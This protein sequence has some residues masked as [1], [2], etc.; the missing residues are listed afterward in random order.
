MQNVKQLNITQSKYF[1]L[2]RV[3]MVINSTN[4]NFLDIEVETFNMTEDKYEYLYNLD[5]YAKAFKDYDDDEQ[6]RW[7]EVQPS[8]LQGYGR[9]IHYE[10]LGFDETTGEPNPK[11]FTKNR[12][13]SITEGYFVKGKLHGYG[14]IMEKDK[15][16][17][18]F[19]KEGKM[20]GKCII[21]NF[22]PDSIPV[23]GIW[24]NNELIYEDQNITDFTS[25]ENGN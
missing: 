11:D 25:N 4:D 5:L 10:A 9:I 17:A 14:R 1:A 15:V 16:I 22:I 8:I 12:L 18:G 24:E 7:S 6:P 23:E 19:F 2:P 13:I 21:Y 20:N 3:Q